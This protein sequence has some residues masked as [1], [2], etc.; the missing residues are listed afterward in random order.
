MKITP[1]LHFFF[2]YTGRTSVVLQ[3]LKVDL[4]T[5]E[6]C[7]SAYGSGGTIRSTHLCTNGTNGTGLCSVS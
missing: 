5:N 2:I 6:A 7:Q 1:V 4:I 3:E